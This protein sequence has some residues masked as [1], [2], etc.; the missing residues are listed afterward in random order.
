MTLNM[1]FF[2][3]TIKKRK[4]TAEEYLHQQNIKKL[5]DEIIDKTLFY[6]NF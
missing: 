6:R 2:T 1:L 4:M 5:R 3:I